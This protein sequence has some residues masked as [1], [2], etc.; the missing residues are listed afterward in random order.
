M[1]TVVAVEHAG[2]VTFGCDSRISWLHE[3]N[4]WCDKVFVN[5]G[6]AIG[7]AGGYRG[8][9]VLRFASLPPVPEGLEGD[10]VDRF[11]FSEFVPAVREAYSGQDVESGNE[12]L[13]VAVLGRAYFISSNFSFI[14]NPDGLYAIGTGGEY[15]L[16]ALK[17]GVSVRDA[18][19]VAAYYDPC[20]NDDV[21]VLEV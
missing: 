16:G 9:Q 12:L 21:R 13:I 10:L 15:A 6:F 5:G 7:A 3:H 1:T 19:R 20:T 4:G 8:S 11:L 14:R 2:G 18:V 17:V